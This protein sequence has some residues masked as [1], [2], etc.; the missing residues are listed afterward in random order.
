MQ[1]SEFPIRQLSDVAPVNTNAA[2]EN[3]DLNAAHH[4]NLRNWISSPCEHR[5][6][7]LAAPSEAAIREWRPARGTRTGGRE[8]NRWHLLNHLHTRP[9][10]ERHSAL[11][12]AGAARGLPPTRTCSR[13]DPPLT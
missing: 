10:K 12:G 6:A 4:H 1:Q 13:S 8:R 2:A 7:P 3:V 5:R 9:I 11:V